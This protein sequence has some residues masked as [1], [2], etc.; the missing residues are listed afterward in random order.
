M[1]FS[2]CA[3]IEASYRVVLSIRQEPHQCPGVI[4]LIPKAIALSRGCRGGA[5]VIGIN[6]SPG[7]W[8]SR[9]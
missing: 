4:R 8:N 1:I 6:L 3:A 5:P 9:L 7:E 2:F